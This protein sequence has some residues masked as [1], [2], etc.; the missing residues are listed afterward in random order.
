MKDLLT[1]RKTQ[2]VFCD[3]FNNSWVCGGSRR[4]S[5]GR[6]EFVRYLTDTIFEDAAVKSVV[7]LSKNA[8]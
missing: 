7:I 1:K 4:R 2:R 8:P 3:L 6:N 5:K